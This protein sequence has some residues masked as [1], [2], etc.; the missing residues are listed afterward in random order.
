MNKFPYGRYEIM[1]N[2]TV[3]EVLTDVRSRT[4]FKILNLGSISYLEIFRENLEYVQSKPL[5][6]GEP[7]SFIIASCLANA[8]LQKKLLTFDLTDD[9]PAEVL[10]I[11]Y[12]IALAVAL[13]ACAEPTIYSLDEKTQNWVPT[14]HPKVNMVIPYGINPSTSLY[15]SI[16]KAWATQ[17]YYYNMK[18]QMR[19][20]IRMLQLLVKL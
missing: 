11:N 3:E 4:D 10:L 5:I 1:V 7:D 13:K 18:L 17:E 12:R 9:T 6:R 16:I 8:L 2:E 14:C 19:S 15:D 20:L